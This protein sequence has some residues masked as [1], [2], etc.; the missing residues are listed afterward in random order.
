MFLVIHSLVFNGLGRVNTGKDGRPKHFQI[1]L[2]DERNYVSGAKVRHGNRDGIRVKEYPMSIQTRSLLGE[3]V[4]LALTKQEKAT[5]DVTAATIFC[6]ELLLKFLGHSKKKDENKSKA[7]KNKKEKDATQEVVEGVVPEIVD[8]KEEEDK[9]EVTKF[10]QREYNGLRQIASDRGAGKQIDVSKLD[11][12][13]T[14][15]LKQ[16]TEEDVELDLFLSGRMRPSKII[17]TQKTGAIIGIT[18]C[19]DERDFIRAMDEIVDPEK[20]D[21]GSAHCGEKKWYSTFTGYGCSVLDLNNLTEYYKKDKAKI[22]KAIL[23]CLDNAIYNQPKSESVDC[24]AN[25]G[26]T[27]YVQVVKTDRPHT[28][29]VAFQNPVGTPHDGIKALK[30]YYK[31]QIAAYED[32]TSTSADWSSLPNVSA[33]SLKDLKSFVTI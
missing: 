25:Q 13:F 1:G 31:A 2:G 21:V 27:V 14:N 17:G 20:V 28:L 3:L 33:G 11:L 22:N 9:I 6:K 29:E 19:S 10:T 4:D 32:T 18:P 7:P 15:V 30:E 16:L 5:K 26:E 12:V 24:P 8:E 23:V